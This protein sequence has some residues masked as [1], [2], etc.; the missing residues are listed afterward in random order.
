M[1]KTDASFDAIRGAI[2]T[3]WRPADLS[4]VQLELSAG[5][6]LFR[7]P[8]DVAAFALVDGR[9][10]REF[11][12]AYGDFKGLY[13][14]NR[15]IW[16]ERTLSFVVCR[17]SE[18][19]ED[20]PFFAALETDPLF[21][22]K[23]VIRAHE[24]VAAQ[25]EELLRLP[26]LPLPADGPEGLQRSAAAQ[27]ILK[28][29][30]VSGSF[31]RNLVEAGRRSAERIAKGLRDGEDSLPAVL[32]QPRAE[33][34]LVEAPRA[35]SRLMSLRVEGFRA[36]R[37]PR[38]FDLD[39]SLVVLYG[40]N[41]LGK[42]S[43]FD[44]IDYAC[45]GRI[46]RLCRTRRR[47]AD[48]A[49]LATHLDKTP[50][51]GSV[52]LVVK[53]DSDDGR[54]WKL[55]RST[56][57]WGSAW[58]DGQEADRKEVINKL[59]QARWMDTTPRQPT[60]DSLFRAT[61]L[62]SQDDQ[63]LLTEFRKG[64]V[65]PETFVS[66]MLS[67]QDYSQGLSKL[68]DVL[69]RLADQRERARVALEALREEGAA[70]ERAL[71]EDGA[72]VDRDEIAPIESLIANLR[73]DVAESS[74]GLPEV[75]EAATAAVFS[76]WRDVALARGRLGAER[77]ALA[78]R[79]RGELGTHHGRIRERLA[80]QTEVDG[81]ERELAKVEEERRVVS[82]RRESERSETEDAEG[83]RGELQRRREELRG[84]AAAHR[85]RADVGKQVAVLVEER[86]RQEREGADI[87]GGVGTEEAEIS[88]A[89][90][91]LAEWDR[92]LQAE[93]AEVR[94][95]EEL[96][97][98][99]PRFI[100]DVALNGDVKRRSVDR[101]EE[102]REAEERRAGANVDLQAAT[103]ARELREPEYR[104]TV[105]ARADL[106]RLLDEIQSH[107]RGHSC[108]LCGSRF[109]SAGSLATSIRS[110]RELG[111]REA[112]VVVEYQRLVAE[113][114]AARDRWE[115]ASAGVKRVRA[116]V[117]ELAAMQEAIGGRME[118]FGKGLVGAG[119]AQGVDP[120]EVEGVLRRRREELREGLAVRTRQVE[121]ARRKLAS[122][123]V[124]RAESRARRKEIEERVAGLEQEV[125]E[126]MERA[127]AWTAE[128]GRVLP[129]SEDIEAHVKR[130]GA[131][132]EGAIVALDARL[133]QYGA[134]RE[135]DDEALRRLDDRKTRLLRRRSDLLAAL[136]AVN[137]LIA[138]FRRELRALGVVDDGHVDSLDRVI[139]EEAQRSKAVDAL[140]ERAVVVRDALHAR[141]T[142]ER[143]D[144]ARTRLEGL[145]V[146]IRDWE[147]QLG[148]INSAIAT[149]ESIDGLLKREQQGSI[150]RHIAAYGPMITM[151]QQ[152]LRAVY[153]FG[154]VRLEARGGEAKVRVKWR[155][156]GVQVPPTDFFSD[157]QK[158]IL[159]L[160]IFIAGGLR[161]NWSG[162]APVLL[163]DPVTHFDDLNAYAFV[164]L[165]RGLVATSSN[166]WQFVVSTCEQR[167]FDLMRKKC[168]RLP[169]GA[170]FYEFVGMTDE[171][172]IVERR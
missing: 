11:P 93:R 48:F 116:S 67:L 122:L 129:D 25:R 117:D 74:V 123:E 32:K 57:D 97:G 100:E 52:A 96:F 40:P 102:L 41:G 125:Q 103:E 136:E 112:G 59:T 17:T 10:D 152:R 94:R 138:E 31:A 139:R 148:R 106:E 114:S 144:E 30:G 95:L 64:S 98:E 77:V 164:E 87:D 153:G 49:R 147:E 140:A 131:S 92:W 75:P 4:S 133:Q 121:G 101:K 134:R 28:L 3:L 142:R 137:G 55:Q 156:R 172:P 154:G 68:K 20:E 45:T 14:A 119:V 16:D 85:R 8:T 1:S 71:G 108:P 39:A 2:T 113:E 81:I 159:M 35:S 127:E 135:S 65:I 51:S 27:D 46:G 83:S 169:S 141:E 58:I 130:E 23:Y 13:R 33:R 111:S 34:L 29:A 99:L 24:S 66:E 42:T 6:L 15:R 120:E 53:N 84:A 44:A 110:Q 19:A 18:R 7:A 161:Q 43:L 50:G 171:G 151:I 9:P 70:L 26:F 63:E 160:S 60:L 170:A 126:L 91:E 62:F 72:D 146:E 47:Q 132:V 88:K 145:G 86:D 124:R 104:R 21:C 54:E 157:S 61:H 162:F 12:K 109:E 38:T 168:S 165:I 90:A 118:E 76:E 56:G 166:D 143:L 149:C 163:D 69:V 167:L 107:V 115:A 150:E 73:E 89:F 37:E 155:S 78:Q 36:Y 79:L 80:A 5:M 82:A 105:A 158:Q 22:R 128:I